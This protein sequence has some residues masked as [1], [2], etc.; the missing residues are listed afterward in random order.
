MGGPEFERY[1]VRP[2]G[3]AV[4]DVC[5]EYGVHPVEEEPE[6]PLTIDELRESEAVI[7]HPTVSEQVEVM[8]MFEDEE[9]ME[10][11]IREA[12]SLAQS[13]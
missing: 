12:T 6:A 11:A 5:A 2:L 13:G 7:M 3:E 9:E 10:F 4:M 8:P 1:D